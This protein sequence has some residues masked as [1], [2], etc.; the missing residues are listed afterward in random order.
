ML[1]HPDTATASVVVCHICSRAF[2]FFFS[3]SLHQQSF[4]GGEQRSTAADVES[5]Q[6]HGH[7]QRQPIRVAT[8]EF[9]YKKQRRNEIQRQAK[10]ESDNVKRSRWTKVEPMSHTRTEIDFEI[11][12]D[13]VARGR[14]EVDFM[15]GNYSQPESLSNDCLKDLDLAT[16]SLHDLTIDLEKTITEE[17]KDSFYRKGYAKPSQS[18]AS[19]LNS[20]PEDLSSSVEAFFA[21]SVTAETNFPLSKRNGNFSSNLHSNSTSPKTP[22]YDAIYQ[23]ETPKSA[24]S[25]T[26]K[27]RLTKKNL[28]KLSNANEDAKSDGDIGKIS[29]DV[30]FSPI[31]YLS[32]TSDNEIETSDS[33]V[34]VQFATIKKGRKSV[35]SQSMES[36]ESFENVKFSKEKDVIVVP[37]K[38][39][40]HR[41]VQPRD[42][43]TSIP[44]YRQTRSQTAGASKSSKS[45][46]IPVQRDDKVS[47]VRN[48][49]QESSKN[50]QNEAV[51]RRTKGNNQSEVKT[52][53]WPKRN[54][55]VPQ[56]STKKTSDSS[57]ISRPK[58]TTINT[59]RKFS[60]T[61]EL[62]EEKQTPNAKTKRF[63]LYYTPQPSRK[64]YEDSKIEK[65]KN[66]ETSNNKSTV[67]KCLV[68][69]KKKEET[70]ATCERKE[71]L[72]SRKSVVDSSTAAS[73]NKTIRQ[74]VHNRSNAIANS[75]RT[76]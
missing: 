28:Y 36:S 4:L 15:N 63:S 26:N 62:R 64:A 24:K 56:Y 37:N 41:K 33:F 5:P 29:L 50:A 51:K 54:S 69:G 17:N 52:D 19:S 7:Q 6:Q 71:S 46:Q 60:S 35:S 12:Q 61:D 42:K 14:D 75:A 43:K 1:G 59:T 8:F 68:S 40:N 32:G 66:A 67:T 23:C 25:T 58:S 27:A 34:N 11:D 16:R 13:D 21:N 38:V 53:V 31:D 72:R 9:D 47:S 49:T 39:A 30:C 70:S 10:D 74:S 18:V 48:K 44:N 76:K 45:S 20:I 65:S 55:Y 57:E 22:V 3:A 2:L 73:R